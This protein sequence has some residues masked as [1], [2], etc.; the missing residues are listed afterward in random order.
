[1]HH[2]PKN[3]TSRP[4]FAALPLLVVSVCIAADQR[5]RDAPL[6]IEVFT[7]SHY[8]IRDNSQPRA[9][10]DSGGHRRRYD[11]DRI[12]LLQQA[13]SQGLSNDP[14]SAK[15]QVLQRLRSIDS[16]LNQRL[17]NTGNGL[18][19]A[20]AYGIDRMPAVV[21]DGQAVVYGV[22]DIEDALVRYR[23]WRDGVGR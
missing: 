10:D 22:T 5:D 20:M 4:V 18:A 7:T 14:E 21:F 8:P 17:E 11:I 6:M 19:Q 13:L 9:P 16:T 12:K 1:M 15:R 23:Q 3:R 2:R